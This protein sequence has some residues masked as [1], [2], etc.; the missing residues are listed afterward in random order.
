[1]ATIHLTKEQFIERVADID[2]SHGHFE[3]LGSRP[4]VIDFYA[5]WCGPCRMLS[6]LLEEVSGEYD[7]KVDIYK[8]NVDEEEALARVFDIRSIPTLIFISKDG[9]MLRSQGAMGKTQLKAA[10]EQNL[11]R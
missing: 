7:G 6:P 1:M 8:V 5:E 11:L 2:A 3:F 10:I 9:S 4:A